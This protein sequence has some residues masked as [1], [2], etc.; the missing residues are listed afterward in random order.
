MAQTQTQIG[1]YKQ[2][3]RTELK[4]DFENAESAHF[5]KG[6]ILYF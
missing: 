5:F 4:K 3:S 6:L 2:V 1:G